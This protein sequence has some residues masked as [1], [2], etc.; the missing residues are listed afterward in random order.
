[1]LNIKPLIIG[2]LIQSNSRKAPSEA[3]TP[4]CGVSSVHIF[5]VTAW[6]RDPAVTSTTGRRRRDS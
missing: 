6:L 1:M 5:S 3:P 4:F 2:S